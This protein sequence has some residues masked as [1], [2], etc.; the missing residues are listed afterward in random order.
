MPLFKDSDRQEIAQ[1]IA[2]IAHDVQLIM[3]TQENECRFCETTR[4][5]VE[6]L[7]ALSGKLSAE[8][9]DLTGDAEMVRQYG[10]TKVPAIV[11][12]GERDYGIRFYG[13]PAGYEFPTL[14][15]A[16]RDVGRRDPE[17]PASILGTLAGIDQ[18]VH[19][20]VMV[21]PT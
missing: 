11:V 8:I 19:L 15:E 10:I 16:V 13:V 18:P 4:Q 12:R 2:D 6:E 20:Q 5:M 17:L 9:R 14:L 1:R 21:T 7:S 3:F